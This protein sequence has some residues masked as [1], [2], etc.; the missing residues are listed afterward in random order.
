MEILCFTRNARTIGA[1]INPI[2]IRSCYNE[3]KRCA[4]SLFF[5]YHRQ[6]AIDI[7]VARIFNTYGPRMHPDD[8]RVVSNFIVQALRGRDITVHGEGLQTRSFC[9]V[10]DMIDGCVR[11]MALP[12]APDRGPGHPGPL[13]LGNPQEFTIRELASTVIE[14]TGSNSRIVFS[15]LPSDDPV[16]RRPDISK[17]R[18]L[19]NWSPLVDLEVGLTKTIRYYEHALTHEPCLP[20][21]T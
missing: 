20:N 10:D 4:E 6:H 15:K 8:G 2:G 5:D 11:F 3:G 7:R 14:M 19:L 9:F 12:G 1:T 18:Q 17:A 21:D 16:R 13:N